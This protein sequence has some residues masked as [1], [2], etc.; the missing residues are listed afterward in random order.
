MHADSMVRSNDVIAIEKRYI[1]YRVFCNLWFVGAIWLLFYR[2]FMTDQSV[3]V[4]DALSFGFGL[5]AEIPS[6]ALADHFGRKKVV[7]I[8]VTLATFGITV[9]GLANGYGLILFGQML[10][11][12]GW[13][14]RSGADDALF[15]DALRY[16]EAKSDWKRLVSRGNQAALIT[17]L[18]SYIVGGVLYRI[19]PRLPFISYIFGLGALYCIWHI[20]ET[21][22][23]G[24]KIEKAVKHY[25]GELREGVAELGNR[26]IVGYLPIICVAQGLFYTFGYGLLRPI[27]QTRFG[28]GATA[29]AIVISICG[30]V[31]V[32]FQRWQLKHMDRLGE[33]KNI[34]VILTLTIAALI[35]GSFNIGKVGFLVILTIYVSEYMLDP[36]VS[37]GLNKHVNSRHRATA[38]SAASFLKSLPYVIAAPII[39]YLNT[40]GRL[41]IYLLG[42]AGLLLLSICIYI[43]KQGTARPAQ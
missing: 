18:L 10:A 30:L 17:T 8:G 12:A 34:L 39:G 1:W 26:N 11:T 29:G 43:Y 28:Y 40:R 27:L 41:H 9:Q 13:A 36:F 37:D 25:L 15:Y 14:F 16:D 24:V 21:K 23:A 4:L 32:I 31:A 33:K 38:L 7:I 5:L 20:P 42:M 22:R 35:A 6:G 2:L 3:G 19:S